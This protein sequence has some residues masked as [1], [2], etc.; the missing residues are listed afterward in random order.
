MEFITQ[1]HYIAAISIVRIFLGFLFFFQGYDAVFNIGIGKVI[2]TYKEGFSSK[3]VPS[4]LTTLAALFT[5]YTELICGA[6][7][8]LGLF[9]IPA[10]YLLGLNL[11]V[12]AI[13]FGMNNP[14]WDMR[15]AFPRLLLLLILLIVPIEWHKW[16]LDFVFFK[17]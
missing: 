9:E 13:G 7:L 3:G 17:L 16:S 8:I 15:H 14:L 5:S 2:A 10:L 1:Y 4:V 6:L 11:I 12:A